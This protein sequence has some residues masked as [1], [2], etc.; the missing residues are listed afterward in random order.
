VKFTE[1]GGVVLSVGKEAEHLVLRVA[2]SGIGISTE[3]RKRLFAPFEQGDGATTRRF[4][5]TGLGLAITKRLVELMG[6]EIR[7]V[8][9][10]GLGTT[11]ELRLPLR[12]PVLATPPAIGTVAL[13]SLGA[14]E[15]CSLRQ[16]LEARGLPVSLAPPD[17][18]FAVPSDLVVLGSDAIDDSA[19][20]S[21]AGEALSR[22]SRWCWFAIRARRRTCRPSCRKPGGT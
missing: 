5:G 20:R 11:F 2:D 15:S 21:R 17:T 10:P 6:G 16:A 18:A 3:Q 19:V 14:A 12:Q 8:S 1:A 22:G 13:A 4:G 9:T 7:V